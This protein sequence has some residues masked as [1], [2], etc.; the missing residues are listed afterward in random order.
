MVNAMPAHFEWPPTKMVMPAWD[1]AQIS[2]FLF[3]ESLFKRRGLPEA[4]AEALA[5]RLAFRD[6]EL[7]RRKVCVECKNFQPHQK[8]CFKRLPVSVVQLVHC[9]GFEWQTP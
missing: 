4:E 6:Y 7:D 8:T 1:D 5:D 9:H 3:R 2:R